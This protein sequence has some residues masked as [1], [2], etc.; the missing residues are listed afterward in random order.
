[1]LKIVIAL[2]RVKQ[3]IVFKGCCLFH[4][5]LKNF[6][7]E[8]TLNEIYRLCDSEKHFVG[9]MARLSRPNLV[10]KRRY[11]RLARF[12]GRREEET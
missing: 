3:I 8:W 7:I 6:W 4:H 5:I 11:N 9:H 10:I 2:G 12:D 1:M